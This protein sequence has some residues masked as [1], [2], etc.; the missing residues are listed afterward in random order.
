MKSINSSKA[1]KAV[2]PYSQA[3]MHNGFL[4]ISGQLHIDPE[5]GKLIDGSI[6][7]KTKQVM[8]NIG[9]IL[10]EAGMDFTN[11]IKSSIFVK[12]LSDFKK[13]N[14]IYGSYFKKGTLPARET[15]QVAN[16]PLNGDIEISVIAGK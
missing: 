4:F 8:E 12:D 10:I 2:G 1:P 15:I 11:V 6:E 3:V 16:L 7:E 9:N 5:T 13:I 14:E